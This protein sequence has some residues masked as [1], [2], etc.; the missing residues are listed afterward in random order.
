MGFQW[1]KFLVSREV[2]PF[3]NFSPFRKRIRVKINC[4]ELTKKPC[5]VIF[6]ELKH[7]FS[8]QNTAGSKNLLKPSDADKT[9]PQMIHRLLQRLE[10][11]PNKEQYRNSTAISRHL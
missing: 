8:F 9:N 4:S 1:I 10:S 6:T 2:L 11:F 5:H 3:S 7:S